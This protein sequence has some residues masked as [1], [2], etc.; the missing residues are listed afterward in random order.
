MEGEEDGMGEEE[1]KL[2]QL[3]EQTEEDKRKLY[4]L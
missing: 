1:K 2:D 4:D 3:G